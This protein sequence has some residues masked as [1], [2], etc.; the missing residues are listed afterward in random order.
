[1]HGRHLWVGI[2]LAAASANGFAVSA[3]ALRPARCAS[4]ARAVA[5]TELPTKKPTLTKTSKAALGVGLASVLASWLP[6]T[7]FAGVAVGTAFA[8]KCY[9]EAWKAAE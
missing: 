2:L 9:Q 3:A 5:T 6:A 1:M 8:A 7:T 4:H